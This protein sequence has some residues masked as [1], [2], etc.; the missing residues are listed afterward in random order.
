MEQDGQKQHPGCRG[1]G[2]SRQNKKMNGYG[3]LL[4]SDNKTLVNDSDIKYEGITEYKFLNKT[5]YNDRVLA[6][7]VTVCFQI[8]EEAKKKSNTYGN[9]VQA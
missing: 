4:L 3:T 9:A 6:K 7:E 2:S 1:R 8:F 5:A